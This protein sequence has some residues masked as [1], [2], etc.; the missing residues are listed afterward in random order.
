MSS[1]PNKKI[2]IPYKP[3][4][5]QRKFHED[6]DS[7]IK[8]LLGGVGS[9]KTKAGSAEAIKKTFRNPYKDGMIVAPYYK[10]LHRVTLKAFLDLCPKDLI[11]EHHKSHNYIELINGSR[12]Y[13]GSA[14][15]PASL[16]GSNLG[17]AWG[18]ELRY[19]KK[20]AYEIL[21]ARVREPCEDSQI[22]FTTT[23]DMGWLFDSFGPEAQQKN[24]TIKEFRVSSE[25]NPYLTEDYCT[26]LKNNY[27]ERLYRAYV[28]GEWVKLQGSVFQFENHHIEADLEDLSL[29]GVVDLAVDTGF[30]KSAVLFVQKHDYC[31]RHKQK[32]CVHVLAEIMPDDTPTVD[33]VGK[34][35]EVLRRN[36]WRVGTIYIDPAANA[37][38]ITVGYSDVDVLEKEGWE[39]RFTTDPDKR[40]ILTGIRLMQNKLIAKSLYFSPLLKHP[41]GIVSAIRSST[42]PEK[43]QSEEPV[44]DGT[45]DHAR[46][47]LRYYLINTCELPLGSAVFGVTF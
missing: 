44:K 8:L 46:D 43:G 47:A 30:R 12:V 40:R 5:S 11:R 38:S 23:P 14:D 19:W 45:Y 33:L 31:K 41:R 39:V 34:I 26:T 35:N 22:F 17:W 7:R 24:P 42:Y 2:I 1:P 20:E 37:S 3:L 25:E 32:D 13:Y 10:V 29:R 21:L 6:R 18:D 9:G 36:R 4:P 16:E 15:N 28:K 27:D